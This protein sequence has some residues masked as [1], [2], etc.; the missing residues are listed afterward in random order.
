MIENKNNFS[1][2]NIKNEEDLSKLRWTVDY[3]EDLEFVK[4]IYSKL[5]SKNQFFGMNEIL[6]LLDENPEIRK[7]NEKYS[8]KIGINNYNNSKEKFKNQ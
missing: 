2:I 7:I 1:I 5:Y 3:E 8:A 6:N 4:K